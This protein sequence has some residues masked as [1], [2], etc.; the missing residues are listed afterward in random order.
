MPHLVY[1]VPGRG[2]QVFKLVKDVVIL[3][4]SRECD[5]PVE[6]NVSSRKHCQLR[7]WAGTYL[8]EDLSS[9]NGT[10]VNGEKVGSTMLKE[11]DL[12]SVGDWTFTYKAK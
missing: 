1:N 2:P 11:G 8:L 3:G 5:L 9:K 10:Y 4:R 12:I 6:D 7:V